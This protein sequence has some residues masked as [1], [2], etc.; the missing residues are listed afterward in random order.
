[1]S[2]LAGVGIRQVAITLRV[3]KLTTEIVPAVR[4]ETYIT[5]RRGS[6]TGRAPRRRCAGSRSP[7]MWMGS[8][9][10]TPAGLLV[11]GVERASVRG[12]LHVLRAGQPVADDQRPHDPPGL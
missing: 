10:H 9:S 6:G 3:V 4:F 11:G 7:G 8:I 1:M 12:E 2:G 5:T